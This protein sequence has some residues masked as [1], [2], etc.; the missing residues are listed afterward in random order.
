MNRR[1]KFAALVGSTIIMG[2]SLRTPTT[3]QY[4]PPVANPPASGGG[5]PAANPPS[6]GQP[7]PGATYAPGLPASWFCT[8][9]DPN[10]GVDISKS[11]TAFLFRLTQMMFGNPSPDNKISVASGYTFYLGI[12]RSGH[13]TQISGPCGYTQGSNLLS[14]ESGGR[15]FAGDRGNVFA[16][17]TGQTVT[18]TR[19]SPYLILRRAA[20]S[21]PTFIMVVSDPVDNR[22][23]QLQFP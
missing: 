7:A 5:T 17:V 8:S 12:D 6:T 13:S 23:L 15:V 20:L 10:E 21:T 19:S 2:C 3:T 18:D 11:G 9:C 16:A 22:K 4:L 1:L 14:C